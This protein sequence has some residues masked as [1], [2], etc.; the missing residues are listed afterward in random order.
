VHGR[1]DVDY[2]RRVDLDQHYANQWSLWLD[3]KILFKTVI[4]ITRR[5]GAY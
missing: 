5:D 4:V 2:S 1:N 3:L